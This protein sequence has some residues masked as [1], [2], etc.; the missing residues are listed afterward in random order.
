EGCGYNVFDESLLELSNQKL[1]LQ[2]RILKAS[3]WGSPLGKE[4]MVK[5]II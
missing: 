1:D 3:L 2:W 4:D 5:K